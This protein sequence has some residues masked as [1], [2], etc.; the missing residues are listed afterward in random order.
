MLAANREASESFITPRAI[1]FG[2][3]YL[4]ERL[5]VGGMAEVY[6]AKCF[7]VAGFERL[8]ALKRILPTIAEDDEFIAMFIDEAKIAG[9]LSHAN[10][11]QIFDL[12]KINA[13][14]FIAME[15][16][17]GHD[18]RALWDRARDEGGLPLALVCYVTRKICEGLDYAHRRR[19]N[20]G[21]PLGIIHRDVSP[22]NILLSYDGDTKVID[23][24]I[25]KAANR[26][27][28]TQTGILKG[29][30]AYMAPEQARGEPTDHRAD[31]F[32]I[33]VI[34]YELITGERCF[35]A[36]S[37][38]ALLE[39]VRRVDIVP[40]RK[41]KPDTPRD[42]ERI[43]FK[44]L[45]R[46]AGDRYAWASALAA[47]LDHFM[48]DQQLTYNKDEL[49]AYVRQMFRDEHNEETRRL[50][51]YRSFKLREDEDGAEELYS[52]DA[53]ELDDP[54]AAE[55]DQRTYVAADPSLSD[56]GAGPPNETLV[57]A[58]LDSEYPLD[59]ESD[60]AAP[61]MQISG[62]QLGTVQRLDDDVDASMTIPGGELDL[63]S[64]HPPI[65]GPLTSTSMSGKGRTR[66]SEDA[67][68]APAEVGTPNNDRTMVEDI[69]PSGLRTPSSGA[70][71]SSLGSVLGPESDAADHRPA[72]RPRAKT[73][74]RL[75][76][77]RHSRANAEAPSSVPTP[78][79]TK[80]STGLSASEA[81]G[82]V[83]EFSTPPPPAPSQTNVGMVAAGSV[84]L[85]LVIGAAVTAVAL[86]MGAEPQPDVVITSEPPGVEV[87]RGEEV[88]CA[89]TPCLGALGEGTHRLSFLLEGEGPVER[90]VT[91]GADLRVAEVKLTSQ[92]VA[93]KVTTTP[94]GASVT[95]NG[96]SVKGET[97]LTL[98]PLRI[99]EDIR[100]KIAL[101][102]YIPYEDMVEVP[103]KS[104]GL[105]T[106][107]LDAT[108]TRWTVSAD[109]TDAIVIPAGNRWGFRRKATV[110]VRKDDAH[111][112]RIMRP[113][114]EAQF[115]SLVGN[116]KP[117]AKREVKLDCKDNDATLKVSAPRK[118]AIL[119]DGV[120][121]SARD[122]RN[123]AIPAGTYGVIVSYGGKEEA[124]VVELTKGQTTKASFFR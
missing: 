91:V 33:G 75:A 73:R 39:K 64:A 15:Y 122:A 98:P 116:G 70:A 10:V 99:G 71:P 79:S 32:A 52:V 59:D 104:T 82:A 29:K 110:E 14:Y 114:C 78:A 44:A 35:K 54:I 1:P 124:Q 34:L 115:I 12:G 38:F 87:R 83:D 92:K 76:S 5:A 111:A 36:D 25:A 13:S 117:E 77:D 22:Q 123:Y 47:D 95:L 109:P 94:A 108:D 85:G 6:L 68:A 105:G 42:L 16:I 69:V 101:K 4:L 27:V 58:P 100:L 86:L 60:D 72:T 17:S 2:N 8:V 106:I 51:Q 26:M 30:F 19:D 45:A 118:A 49:G 62:D 28:R 66:V 57:G 56:D 65:D 63:A 53:S 112:V 113:G 102:G 67:V 46:E 121:F 97:P 119:I 96:K 90:T 40:P 24:G 31:I 81:Y 88:V 3:Y 61:T 20:R 89:E 21:R 9:Q 80:A 74:P 120:S 11:A 23:F 7:G 37:D 48:S 107:A 50:A 55:E 43:I 84:F 18:L 103:T 41:I 93:L